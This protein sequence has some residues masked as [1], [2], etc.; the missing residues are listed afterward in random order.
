MATRKDKHAFTIAV[1]PGSR[2]D[3]CSDPAPAWD[4]PCQSFM[5]LGGV[6]ESIDAWIACEACHAFIQKGDWPGLAAHSAK[7]M[8]HEVELV[9]AFHSQFRQ[10]RMGE[11]SRFGRA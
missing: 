7:R 3:F 10:H 5:T 1:P 2:C 6:A 11:P 4:Y 9:A 8:G